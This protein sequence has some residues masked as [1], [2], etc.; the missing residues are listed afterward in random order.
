MRV[1]VC[2]CARISSSRSK[3]KM[4]KNFCGTTLTDIFLK[5]L[6]ILKNNNINVFFSGYDKIFE[7]KCKK[8]GIPFVKRSK[9]SSIVDEPASVIYSFLLNQDYDYFLFVN[10]CAPLLKVETIM[11]FLKM[12]LKINKPCFAVYETKNYFLNNNNKP[13]NF[14]LSLKTINTK[15]VEKLKEFAHIFYFFKKDYF[16]SKGRFWNWKDVTYINIPR[17]FETFDIDTEKDFQLAKL[18]YGHY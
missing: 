4:I 13:I 15:N 11:N 18:L 12:C 1:A 3:K 14:D 2:S 8:F 5:K 10:A 6:K 17:S 7:I 16:K 9:K